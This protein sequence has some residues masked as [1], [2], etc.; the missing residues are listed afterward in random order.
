MQQKRLSIRMGMADNQM[1][2]HQLKTLPEFFRD[3]GSLKPFDV[4]ENDRD[5]KVGDT[6]WLQ[7]WTEETGYTGQA[8]QFK[9]SYIL[10]GSQWGIM[11]GYCIMGLERDV[12]TR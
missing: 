3:V 12:R 11:D 6:L 1:T 2:V 4:R 10:Q 9:V 8:K 7:E 5:F